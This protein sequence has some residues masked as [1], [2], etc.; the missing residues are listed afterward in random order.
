MTMDG[1]GTRIVQ[2]IDLTDTRSNPDGKLIRNEQEVPRGEMCYFA[3]PYDMPM[4][5]RFWRRLVDKT[6]RKNV[7]MDH[8]GSTMEIDAYTFG[9]K[10]Y[11]KLDRPQ[12]NGEPA[13]LSFIVEDGDGREVLASYEGSI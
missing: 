1:K 8:L 5:I 9:V 11:L 4:Y 13:K 3:S 7:S 12:K 10:F 2:L 6:V